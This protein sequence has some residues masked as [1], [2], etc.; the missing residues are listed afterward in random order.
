MFDIVNNPR[1]LDTPQDETK[2]IG[3]A[4][5]KLSIKNNRIY[6]ESFKIINVK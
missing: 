3:T 2:L 5:L 4:E 6:Y 1:T